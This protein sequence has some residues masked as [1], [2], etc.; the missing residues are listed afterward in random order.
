MY[1]AGVSLEIVA[2]AISRHILSESH[3]LS[4]HLGGR[5]AEKKYIKASEPQKKEYI[6][7]AEPQKR[8][9]SKHYGR[10]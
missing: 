10:L 8:S 7:A 4:S 5:A 2:I 3:R 6:K 1:R 9:T